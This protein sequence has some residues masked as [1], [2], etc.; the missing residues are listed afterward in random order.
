[1]ECADVALLRAILNGWGT[2]IRTPIYDPESGVPYDETGP[3]WMPPHVEHTAGILIHRNLNL[4]SDTAHYNARAAVWLARCC[5]GLPSDVLESDCRRSVLTKQ[6]AF[7][8][9]AAQHGRVLVPGL[10]HNDA[11]TAAGLAQYE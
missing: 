6:R 8:N 1:M 10:L 7:A 4:V 11:L 2:G 3:A 9:V 5:D